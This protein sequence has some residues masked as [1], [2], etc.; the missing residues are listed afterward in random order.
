[1][2]N[3]GI[4][5]KNEFIVV[6]YNISKINVYTN[7]EISLFSKTEL[8]IPIFNFLYKGIF[9]FNSFDTSITLVFIFD[10]KSFI[11]HYKQF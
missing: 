7:I 4:I 9:S 8:N 11:H 10:T 3:I 5:K 1:M 2:N 6:K